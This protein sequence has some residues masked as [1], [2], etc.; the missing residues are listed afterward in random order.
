[1]GAEEW[2]IAGDAADPAAV[3]SF[4]AALNRAQNDSLAAERTAQ[5]LPYI[6]AALRRDPMFPDPAMTP[7]YSSLLTLLALGSSR[8]TSI[9]DSSLVLVDALLS[10]G[11]DAA[12]YR[13]LTADVNEIA[14][15]GFGVR[16]VYWALELIEAFMRSPAP[17]TVARERLVHS[18]LARL[19]PIRGRLSWLQQ[20]A[21]QSLSEEF[22]W[23]L[24]AL[25]ATQSAQDD[26]LA[27]RL[28]GKTIAI[29]SLVENASRQAKAALQALSS[30]IDVQ[31]SANQGGSAQLRALAVNS[32]LFVVAWAAA[33]HAAT[34]FIRAHRSGRPLVYAEGTGVSSLLRA[35][36]EFFNAQPSGL[37]RAD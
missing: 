4:L 17:D 5:A 3:A 33:K 34:D 7:I 15:E 20:A 16:M 30:E 2:P 14:G 6:V 37:P 32:D 29:Y 25:P 11:T 22:G 19:T 35:I 13:E 31:C 26:R 21:V 36:E 8:G 1:L 12:Q 28:R 10:V 24:D 9:F 27:T 23:T 18:I